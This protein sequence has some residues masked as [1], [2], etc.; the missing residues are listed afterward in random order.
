MEQKALSVD[1]VASALGVSAWNVREMVA[2]GDLR[3]VRAGK[4]ILIPTAALED[5][6]ADPGN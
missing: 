6:L 4:R 5:F 1:E 3:S 2:R